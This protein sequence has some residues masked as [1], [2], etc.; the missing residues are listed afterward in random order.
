MPLCLL[1]AFAESYLV[2]IA[3]KSI[4]KRQPTGFGRFDTKPCR[5]DAVWE[6]QDRSHN[7]TSDHSDAHGLVVPRCRTVKACYP[8]R[9]GSTHRKETRVG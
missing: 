8:C 2:F 7:F 5:A 9:W 3:S 6:V 1:S 4:M